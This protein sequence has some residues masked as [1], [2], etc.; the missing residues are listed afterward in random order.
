M[1]EQHSIDRREAGIRDLE[2]EVVDTLC[3]LPLGA[4]TQWRAWLFSES[5]DSPLAAHACREDLRDGVRYLSAVARGKCS[6][7]SVDAALP[8]ADRL[9]WSRPHPLPG[10]SEFDLRSRTHANAALLGLIAEFENDSVRAV[11]GIAQAVHSAGMAAAAAAGALPDSESEA[12]FMT[13]A[14]LAMKGAAMRLRYPEA[15]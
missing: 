1:D 14:L 11:F 2:K 6:A 10:E 13:Q 12:Y 8:F 7:D 5:G 4:W 9:R 3:L 15:A